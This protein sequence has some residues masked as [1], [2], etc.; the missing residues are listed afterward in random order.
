MEGM[1]LSA[2][3]P[4]PGWLLPRAPEWTR[5]GRHSHVSEAPGAPRLSA[6]LSDAGP[7]SPAAAGPARQLPR[8]LCPTK[9]LTAARPGRRPGLI[10]LHRVLSPARR[11][12]PAEGSL[13]PVSRSLRARVCTGLCFGPDSI[14]QSLSDC[15]CVCGPLCFSGRPPT[16]ACLPVYVSLSLSL[17]VCLSLSVCLSLYVCLSLS[18]SVCLS[19]S[20]CLALSVPLSAWPA[21]AL[22]APVLRVSQAPSQ[23]PRLR[24][25]PL[26]P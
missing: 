26:T 13:Q 15:P 23:P 1:H 24:S 14:S 3:Q 11:A 10:R 22:P 8:N 19:V 21:L 6:C 9:S 17:P 7:L 4:V 18:T 12:R 5:L 25:E 16:P 20:P 2:A